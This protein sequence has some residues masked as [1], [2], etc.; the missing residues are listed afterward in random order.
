MPGSGEGTP[1]C[2][3][4]L[5]GT[6]FTV[7]WIVYDAD[8]AIKA[9]A[10]K[11]PIQDIH[12]TAHVHLAPTKLAGGAGERVLGLHFYPDDHVEFEFRNDLRGT[13]TKHKTQSKET[14][15]AEAWQ[16]GEACREDATE[17]DAP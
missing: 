3:Y 9:I 14:R 10:A 16:I 5:K 13:R 17:P 7:E 2:C 11:Q 1:S 15:M 6:E 4:K 8:E 12:K